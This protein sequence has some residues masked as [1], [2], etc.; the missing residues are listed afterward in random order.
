[1]AL[2][3]REAL[4]HFAEAIEAHTMGPRLAAA[5]RSPT[6]ACH[7]LDGKFQPG[8]G[9]T[10]LYELGGWLVRGDVSPSCGALPPAGVPVVAPG[11][12]LH[13][14]PDDPDLPSLPVVMDP[15]GVGQVLESALGT[16]AAACVPGS[17]WRTSL[18]R[19][20]PGKR[21]TVL[22]V[23]RAGHRTYVAKVYHDAAKA[24]A[25][26]NEALALESTARSAAVL[27]FAPVVTHLAD[28]A[29]VVQSAV[30]GTPLSALLDPAQGPTQT[31]RPAVR[32]AARAVAELHDAGPP[33]S[34]RRSVEQELHRFLVRAAAV[35]EVAPPAGQALLRLAE[36]LRDHAARLRAPELGTVHGD[37]KPSQFVLDRRDIYLLDVDHVG[38]SDVAADVGTFMASLRQLAVQRSQNRRTSVSDVY[39]QLADAF[40]QEYA[41]V[42][43]SRPDLERIRWQEAVALERKAL[44]AFARAPLSPLVVGL[45]TEAHRC[46]DRSGV[47]RAQG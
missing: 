8:V 38:L 42:R 20:R 36:R 25:V 28:L 39:D 5:L 13:R 24:A 35:R 21:A 30:G 10:V 7:V 29:T 3:S 17:R 43:G 15:A 27:R 26:A 14:F 31:A 33:T 44:R 2:S 16:P 47:G 23:H 12:S 22:V 45:T 37:C 40:L 6:T 46:L 11:V 18:L 1:M 34:R 41:E 4:A 19:Y 32:R 9:A